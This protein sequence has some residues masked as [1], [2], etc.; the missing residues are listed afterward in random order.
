MTRLGALWRWLRGGGGADR[1]VPRG[2]Q[3][4]L[5]VGFL[6]AVMGFFAVL[7][8]ALALAAGRLAATWEGEIADTATLQVFAAEDAIEEQARAALN[9]LRTTPGV[10]S[11]RVVDLAEQ[12]QLLEPWLG[13]D[14]PMES[15]PLPLLIEV[16]TDRERLNPQSLVLRLRGGGAGRGLRRPRRLAPAAGR[17]RRAAAD[18]RAR[19]PRADGAGA[20]RGARRSRRMRAVAANG[21]AIQTLRLVGAATASSPAPSPGASPCARRAGALVGTLAAIGLLA[22]AAAGERAGVLPRRDRARRLALGAAVRDPAGRRR[23]RLGGDL[24]CD[25]ARPAPLEL[26][27]AAA[28]AR[29][30][31]TS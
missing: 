12:E 19:L 29:W 28:V 3:S 1:V 4:A 8:L 20:R 17:D 11:V 30:S 23:R 25:A 9:V 18:L 26:S 16:A 7:A 14:I 24:G 2:A 31:S 13:P 22:A 15:L 6:A 5:S 21:A 27:D 10:R